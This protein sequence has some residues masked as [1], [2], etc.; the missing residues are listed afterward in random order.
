MDNGVE[1]GVVVVVHAGAHAVEHGR[2]LEVG[3]DG[4]AEE[5]GLGPAMDELFGGEHG[6]DGG[7]LVGADGAAE[8]VEEAP[9]GL[10][11]G[12]GRNAVWEKPTIWGPRF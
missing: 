7:M 3:P 5:G 9:L 11:Q 1:E 10:V 2:E 12:L 8:P 4:G 6:V